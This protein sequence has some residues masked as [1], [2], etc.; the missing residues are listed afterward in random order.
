MPGRRF[1]M[2]AFR[3]FLHNLISSF[4]SPRIA[5]RALRSVPW[6][7]SSLAKYRS[8]TS[9]KIPLLHLW[10]CLT[11]R[12]EAGGTSKGDYFHQDLWAAKKV[13]ESRCPD[14]V[15]VASRVD[16]FVA[17][18]AIFARVTYVD[19]RPIETQIE[20]IIPKAG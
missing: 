16:G 20:N 7:F 15:D 4:F 14:H 5:F 11:D 18:C 3:F 6:Y 9:E 8:M 10:P 2:K 19:I 17:H 12:Y 1:A 13:Y